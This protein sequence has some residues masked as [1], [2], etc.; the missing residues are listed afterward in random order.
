MILTASSENDLARVI[1]I[2]CSCS[3]CGNSVFT[4]ERDV[5]LCALYNFR[6]NGNGEHLPAGQHRANTLFCSLCCIERYA[7][8]RSRGYSDHY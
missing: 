6:L 1:E 3:E 4:T 2:N 5:L 8:G 7:I